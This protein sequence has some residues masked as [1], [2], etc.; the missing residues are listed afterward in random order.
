MTSRKE[1]ETEFRRKAIVEAAREVFSEKGYNGTTIDNVAARAEFAKA[2]LYKFFKNKEDLY[3]SVVEDVFREINEIAEKA[4]MEDLPVRDKFALFID[5]LIT[6]FSDH[7]DFFR[8]LMREVG[9]INMAGWKGSPHAEI[10]DKL[11]DI[12]AREL[13]RGIKQKQIKKIDALRAAQVFNHMVYA[14]HMNNLFYEHDE[15]MRKEAVDF[16][17]SVFFDGIGMEGKSK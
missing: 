9:R 12:L 15:K 11:N 1:R 4:M 8:L 5:R 16:L 14:Y 7:A 10:H 13:N 6:R 17:V 2:T 3:L